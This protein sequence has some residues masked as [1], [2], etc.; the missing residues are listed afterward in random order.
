MLSLMEPRMSVA[1]AARSVFVTILSVRPILT[2]T[3]RTCVVPL[4]ISFRV[5]CVVLLRVL[6]HVRM[7]TVRGALAAPRN[8]LTSGL[9]SI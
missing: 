6:A 7:I 5:V 3:L 4:R 2:S 8:A 1:M 9:G